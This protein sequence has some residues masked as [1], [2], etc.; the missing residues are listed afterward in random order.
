MWMTFPKLR[1]EKENSDDIP[2]LKGGKQL[3][4]NLKVEKIRIFQLPDL[5]N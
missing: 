3:I 5:K 4:K 2:K 1:K